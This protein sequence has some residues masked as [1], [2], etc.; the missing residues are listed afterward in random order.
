MR[1]RYSEQGGGEVISVAKYSEYRQFNVTVT[2]SQP[3]P[4]RDAEPR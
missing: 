2:E 1:E 4:R 3:P